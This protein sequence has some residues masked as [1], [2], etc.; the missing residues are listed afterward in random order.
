M[1]G[2]RRV[3]TRPRQLSHSLDAYKPT[4][5]SRTNT[6]RQSESAGTIT[7]CRYAA[8]TELHMGFR[9][10]WIAQARVATDQLLEAAN[11]AVTGERH[12]FP[13]TGWYLLELPNAEAQPWVVLIADGSDHFA[14]LDASDA[15]ELSKGGYETIYFWCSDTVMA[16]E[17]VA[18]NNGIENW[19][20]Q[21]DCDDTSKQPTMN[22]NVPAVANEIFAR[23]KAQQQAD[24]SADYVY[25]LTAELGRL[26]VGFRHDM[27][28]QQDDPEPFQVLK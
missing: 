25:D 9:V 22:G 5:I 27:D 7:I 24:S 21:Y 17:I 18:F 10:S 4:R 6:A 16:T 2:I 8:T 20:V 11:R 14:E 28:V 3:L 19:S 26:L 13:D 15:Q 1:S 23:L 12:D